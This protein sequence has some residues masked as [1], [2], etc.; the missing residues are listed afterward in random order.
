MI[1]KKEILNARILIIDD[2]QINIDL[3]EAI[4]SDAGYTSVLSITDPREALT[5]YKAYVPHLVLLD[6]KMP[7]LDGY[8]V[9]ELFKKNTQNNYVP[10]LVMTALQDDTTR[11]KALASGAQDF[12]TKPFNK[13]EALTR[14]HNLLRI[15]LLHNQVQNQ[16]IILEQTVQS[17]TLELEIPV[18]KLS[19]SWDRQLNIAIRKQVPILSE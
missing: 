4:V 9:M 19:V 5:L 2:H 18:L 1:S 13:L 8:E 7:H 3:L 10:V 15:K 6:I 12:L 16:N 14:I 11:L 17:R